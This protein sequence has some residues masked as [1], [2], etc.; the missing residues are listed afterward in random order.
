MK[1]NRNDVG[2]VPG[3]DLPFRL[4][5]FTF[6]DNTSPTITYE[7]FGSFERTFREE[8]PHELS[9]SIDISALGQRIG[10]IMGSYDYQHIEDIELML[11]SCNP[12]KNEDME[13]IKYTINRKKFEA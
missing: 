1:S 12:I 8:A 13:L 10:K 6:F 11:I 5:V 9:N 2:P 3:Y 7:K 4:D